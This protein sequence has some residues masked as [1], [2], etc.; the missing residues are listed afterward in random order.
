MNFQHAF[1]LLIVGTIEASRVELTASPAAV[2]PGLTRHMTVRCSL[3]D[4]AP[5]VVGKRETVVQT[6]DNVS[7]VSSIIVMLDGRDIASVSHTSPA[8]VMDGSSNLQVTGSVTPNNGEQGYLELTFDFPRANNSGEFV[9]EVNAV[10]SFH[11]IVFSTSKEVSFRN[12]TIDDMANYI[13]T[14]E[15]E[16]DALVQR[17]EKLEQYSKTAVAFSA[18]QKTILTTKAN[19][20]VLYDTVFTNL[21][22]AFNAGTG[23]F[24]CP[25]DGY[26]QFTYGGFTNKHGTHMFY[27]LYKNTTPISAVYSNWASGVSKEE[28]S[29]NSAIVKL[30]KGDVVKVVAAQD[31]MVYNNANDLYSSFSGHLI[32]PSA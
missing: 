21:G 8:Q 15:K 18:A 3:K 17:I 12:L 31:S 4:T 9:C 11:N 7:E 22:A 28:G 13:E 16:K 5:A 6:D 27:R 24:I 25:L 19:I 20:N 29:S 14:N 1:L 32:W 26:Y 23:E 10:R 30:N 2:K